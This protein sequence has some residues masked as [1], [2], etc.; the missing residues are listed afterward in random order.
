[1]KSRKANGF[2]LVESLIAGA[3]AA[4]AV[5][6]ILFLLAFLRIHN[7]LEQERNR[8]FQIVTQAVDLERNQLFSWTQSS[9]QQT[10]WDHGTPDDKLDDTVG[11]LEVNVKNP[12]TG[13]VLSSPPDPA[14]LVEVEAT[15]TW[16][17]R[18]GRISDKVFRETAMTYKVP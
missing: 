16:K 4:I 15:L 11:E 2:T 18:G 5:L 9:R 3:I 14:V 10:I 12:K 7:E 1:M 8:A 13:E 17:H 6:G